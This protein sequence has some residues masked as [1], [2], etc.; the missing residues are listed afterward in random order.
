MSSAR[1][2]VAVIGLVLLMNVSLAM[3]A[4]AGGGSADSD[5][6]VRVCNA[7]ARSQNQCNSL[8]AKLP[9]INQL[10][11]EAAALVFETPAQIRPVFGIP[12]GSDFDA[13]RQATFF[14]QPGQPL[15]GFPMPYRSLAGQLAFTAGH[16]QTTPTSVG[17]PAANSF[18]SAVTAPITSNPTMLDLTFDFHP[19]TTP[20]FA[21]GQDVGDITLPLAVADGRGNR[22][23]D[24]TA[25]VEIFGAG[26][27]TTVTDIHGD[28]L[29]SREILPPSRLGITSS[30]NFI[31]GYLEFSLSVPIMVTTD[32][33]QPF[34]VSASGVALDANDFIGLDPLAS[35][36]DAR[37]ADN[38][39]DISRA[40]VAD[41]AIALDG[42]VLLSVPAPLPVPA[43]EPTTLVL[44][45]NGVI[46]F[47]VLRRRRR[48]T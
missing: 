13:G 48:T 40:M 44:L 26:G 8:A 20:T 27:T 21:V 37:F 14:Y 3:P 5:V 36:L 15:N 39:G 4:Q 29:G 32:I 10:V 7:T 38:N 30:L 1:Q 31:N 18:F 35:F 17:N 12:A 9:T 33:G 2:Q 34:F 23:R 22:L 46:G 11:L 6:F 47:A 28:F 24:V 43:P 45:G 41:L 19:R 16:E 42:S 25:T